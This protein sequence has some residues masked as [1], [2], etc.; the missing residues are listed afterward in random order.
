MVRKI[1][2]LLFACLCLS[3]A[4]FSK[5]IE[6]KDVYLFAY[7]IDEND[8]LHLAYSYDGLKWTALNGDR[9][10]L[11]PT[12]GRNKLM[13]DP[14]IVR[15]RDGTFHMVWTVDWFGKTIGYASSKD[16]VHWS[17]QKEI[18]VMADEPACE[19]CWAPELFLD[20]KTDTY[21]ILWSS[22]VRG[23]Q[24]S[25]PT[26]EG[27]REW[28]LEKYKATGGTDNDFDPNLNHR[29]YYTTTKDFKN[30]AKSNIY[31]NPDFNTIDAAIAQDPTTGKYIMV[32]KNENTQPSEK[33]IRITTTDSLEKGFPT[34]VSDAITEN[35]AE[36][37][38]PLFIGDTLYVYFDKYTLGRYGAVRSLDHGKT[39]TDV[40]DKVSFPE[41]TKHGTAFKVDE[42]VLDMLLP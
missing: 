23:R 20:K 35:G 11:K 10:F 17:E 14:S 25:V 18:P 4:G 2:F 29:I 24:K 8:G 9:S 15:G 27:E 5:G 31:F 1:L 34:E 6:A 12:I 39:W 33:N 26:A 22:T 30:F 21:Y 37:P 28:N 32:V 19:N 41:G 38:S 3:Q 42:S 16:L 36:G 40:S 13:R 7:F